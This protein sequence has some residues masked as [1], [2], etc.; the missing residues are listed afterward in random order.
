MTEQDDMENWNYAHAAS[1]GI[2]ARRHPYNYGMGL[3]FDK[4]DAG[5]PGVTTA[6]RIT[7]ENARAFYTRWAQLM[8]SKSW[9]HVEGGINEQRAPR[10]R[11]GR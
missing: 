9:D 5:F 1:R 8:D 2:I 4:I 3:K 7:E 10:G 11:N 6:E